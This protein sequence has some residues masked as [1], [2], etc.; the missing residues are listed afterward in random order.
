[1]EHVVLA[2]NDVLHQAVSCFID[3]DVFLKKRGKGE[4]TKREIGGRKV[5]RGRDKN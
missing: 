2:G 3:V 5:E 4:G 1:M